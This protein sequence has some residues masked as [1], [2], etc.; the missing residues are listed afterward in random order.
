MKKYI[1]L[2]IIVLLFIS[3]CSWS[4]VNPLPQDYNF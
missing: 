4:E 3:G 1:I 2:G